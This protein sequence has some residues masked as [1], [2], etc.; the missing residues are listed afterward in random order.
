[1]LYRLPLG[2]DGQ[3]PSASD[4]HRVPLT[5]AIVYAPG[6]NANGLT[7]TP[8]GRALLV[9]GLPTWSCP[10]VRRPYIQ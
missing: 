8:D 9:P 5:G 10:A 6:F 3:L 1:V 7:R 2:P 4:V